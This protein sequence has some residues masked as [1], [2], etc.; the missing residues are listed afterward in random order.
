MDG[1][2]GSETRRLSPQA[3]LSAVNRLSGEGNVTKTSCII[4]RWFD[5]S[6]VCVNW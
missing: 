5:M 3:R 4:S 2:T 1:Q 6:S